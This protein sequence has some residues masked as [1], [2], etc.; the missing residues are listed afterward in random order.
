MEPDL[1]FSSP[2][3]VSLA[4]HA[5][6]MSYPSESSKPDLRGRKVLIVDDDR[7]NVRILSGIL[8]SEGF[9]LKDADS[10]EAALELYETFQPDLVLLDVVMPGITG[11]EACRRLKAR[12]GDDLAPVIFI[13]AKAESDD[14]V[15]GLAAGGVDYLPKP[16]R[17]REAVARIRT[18]LHNRLLNEQQRRLVEQLSSANAAK[19]KLLGMVAHD[20]RNP[21]ASIK[22]LAEFL[23]DDGAAGK[24]TADQLDL[25]GT[26]HRTSHAMLEMVNELLDASVIESGELRIHLEV[27]SPS[28]I[29]EHSITLN[30]INAAKKGTRIELQRSHLPPTL[31]I[32]GAKIRQVIDNLLSNAVKFSP[33]NS[34]VVVETGTTEEHCALSVLDQGPGIPEDEQHKLF[35]DFGRTS[36]TPTAGEKSTGLGLAICRRIIEAHGGR[37]SASNRPHGGSVF[38]FTLPRSP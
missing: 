32:D 19:N 35:K 1:K 8:K 2:R 34:L 23:L 6:S 37:I 17:P 13:T 27:A 33:P 36:V 28:E 5:A 25:A 7:V 15:E 12:H 14:V 29:L 38:Q 31:K 26:I 11:F 18:H 30:N 3:A 21:L 24:L 20:L 4:Y 10:G 16:F 9:A 22:G